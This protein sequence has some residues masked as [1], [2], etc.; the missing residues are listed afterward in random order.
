LACTPGCQG[1]SDT[2]SDMPSSTDSESTESTAGPTTDTTAESSETGTTATQTDTTET[3]E[4]GPTTD[5]DSLTDT[6]SLTDTD[7]LT[8][9]S[10]THDE[11]IWHSELYPEEWT[12]G[13]EG[14]EG[15]FLH[16]FS[17]AGYHNAEAEF[18][19]DLPDLTLDVVED[20]GADPAG[21]TDATAAFQAA[22]DA[23]AE[24]GGAIIYVPPG[25]YRLDGQ[26]SVTS[27]KIVLR[28]AGADQS[29][30]WMTASQGMSFKSHITF[31][32]SVASEDPLE[33]VADAGVFATSIEVAD[34]NNYSPGDD[35]VIGWTITEEFIEEHGMTDVWMAFN[36]QWQ[37]FF[38]RTVTGVYTVDGVDRIDLD[39][40]LRYPAK[41]RDQAD[42]RR[43]P[44]MLH[45]VAVENLGIADAVAWGAAW[46]QDQVHVIEFNGVADAWIDGVESYPSPGAPLNG[47][48]VDRHLQSGGII[49]RQSK[50]VSVANGHLE[51]PQNRGGGGNGYLYEVRQSSEI[52]FRDLVALDGRHNFIQ[53]WGFGATGIVWLGI[54][55][56]GSTAVPI[57]GLDIGLPAFSEFHHSLAT[58][59]LID[60]STLDDGWAAANRGDYSSG[61]GH[62]ATQSVL[63][64][65]SG[66]G[67]LRS[68]Q[69]GHGYIIGPSPSLKIETSLETLDALFSEPEDWH[70]GPGKIGKLDPESLYLDQ[71]SRRMG[72]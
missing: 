18:G 16:D 42:V 21:D 63:W 31:K 24:A 52:L 50:R 13:Y 36:G 54:Y 56:A 51:G 65:I 48:G 66:T 32:G 6:E 29:R 45:E 62:S 9:S 5:T 26:I 67:T 15:Q 14:P 68:R 10:D 37:P 69:F 22:I 3:S 25:L 38:W 19:Q 60:A 41:L 8:D 53:N 33:L 71:L 1:S 46:E 17:Y 28:G 35:I 55:S 20:Y 47:M 57:D 58:A 11:E 2:D 49:V 27:S 61:A 64:N 30:L 44:G 23:G 59:N 7:S 12:P 72:G 70:E 43:V 40:P 34:A 39:V 4:T